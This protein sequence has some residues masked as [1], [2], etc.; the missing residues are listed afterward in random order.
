[1]GAL[2]NPEATRP[3]RGGEP[4][5]GGPGAAPVGVGL[6]GCGRIATLHLRAWRAVPG[7][8][9]V[10]VCDTDP[11]RA[12]AFADRAGGARAYTELEGLLANPAVEAV[13]ILTPHDLHAEHA[14]AA[15]EAGRHVSLQK[16]PA[17]SLEEFDRIAAV[18]RREGRILR[19][20]ENFRYH[21]PHRRAR[22]LLVSG[23]IG[24]WLGIRMLTLAGRPGDGWEVPAS[25]L[26]WRTDPERCGGG[27]TTFDHGYHVYS[28]A[29][30]FS[31]VEVAE[32]HAFVHTFRLPGGGVHDG[33]A[34]VSWRYDG[35]VPRM[36]SWQVAACLGMRLRSDY[37]PSDDRMEIFGSEGVLFV[38]GCT[39]RL[40]EEP[41]LVLYRDGETRAFHDLETDWWASFRDG[42]AAFAEAV[43][44]GAAVEESAE[45]ARHTLAMAIAVARS[46][47]EDRPVPLAE[48]LRGDA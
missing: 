26:A 11:A 18:A 31:P 24:E 21:P 37:Y 3:G 40:L 48:V 44:T 35:P 4:A 39:G 13:E 27:P 8:R 33:P 15:L 29:R 25:A 23:A 20:F 2:R 45:G 42:A 5:R 16:P 38:N 30:F 9:V 6:V 46:A 19:V 36:G 10:A 32:V 1:M 34:V 28:M 14:L 22:A 43:R 41:A 17:R 47:E 12:A 7:A